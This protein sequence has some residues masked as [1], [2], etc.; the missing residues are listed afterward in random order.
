MPSHFA[1]YTATE[2]STGLILLREGIPI[3]AAIE[4]LVL[5]WN[6]K[7]PE[8]QGKL[9]GALKVHPETGLHAEIPV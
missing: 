2:V 9:V 7:I 8:R 5:I 4:E 1:R 6:V 3:A